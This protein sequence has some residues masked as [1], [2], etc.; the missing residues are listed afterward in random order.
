MTHFVVIVM[1]P[2]IKFMRPETCKFDTVVLSPY[3]KQISFKTVNDMHTDMHADMHADTHADTYMRDP[4]GTRE[5]FRVSEDFR[6]SKVKR[7]KRRELDPL[8]LQEVR[9]SVD[10]VLCQED[11]VVSDYIDAIIAT[12]PPD[13]V[14][15]IYIWWFRSFWR[16]Y[17]PETGKVPAWLGRKNYVDKTLWGALVN[18]IHFLHLPFNTLEISKKW[19]LGCQCDFCKKGGNVSKKRKREIFRRADEKPGFFDSLFP[20]SSTTYR[21]IPGYGD[22]DNPH[23]ARGHRLNKHGLRG[24]YYYDCFYGTP[25]EWDTK[26]AVRDTRRPLEFS[27]REPIAHEDPYSDDPPE[28]SYREPIAHE[29]PDDP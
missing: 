26:W 6:K 23:L 25:Y 24:D 7:Y 29:D 21:Y 10:K 2:V 4:D 9:R 5:R 1:I 11:Q 15:R 12:L 20:T 13:M 28:F 22:P 27:Y 8:M 14:K 18:N 17:V 19:I 16:S 3:L